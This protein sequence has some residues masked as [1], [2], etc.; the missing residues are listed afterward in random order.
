[1]GSVTKP[2]ASTGAPAQPSRPTPTSASVP[3]GSE[4]DTVKM[5]RGWPWLCIDACGRDSP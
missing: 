2:P 1:V 5:V 4:V 3:L